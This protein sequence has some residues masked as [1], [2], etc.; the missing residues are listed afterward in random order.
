MCK[1]DE[2]NEKDKYS[3]SIFNLRTNSREYIRRIKL[4]FYKELIYKYANRV[5]IY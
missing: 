1:D 4:N 2:Y 3:H 5:Y